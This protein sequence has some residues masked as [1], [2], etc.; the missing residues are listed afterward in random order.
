MKKTV[1]RS[2][3]IDE[4]KGLSSTKQNLELFKLASRI[5]FEIQSLRKATDKKLARLEGAVDC[6]R[7]D[8]DGKV[9]HK[10]GNDKRT[11]WNTVKLNRSYNHYKN[12][13]G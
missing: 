13:A 9:S 4:F 12:I 8:D 7:E 10:S 3:R 6:L 2:S 1:S 11:H 5:S